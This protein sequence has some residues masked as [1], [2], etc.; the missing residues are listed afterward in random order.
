MTIVLPVACFAPLH[1][2]AMVGGL[3]GLFSARSLYPGW[4]PLHDQSLDGISIFNVSRCVAQYTMT[5]PV[6]TCMVYA[7]PHLPAVGLIPQAWWS[8]LTLDGVSLAPTFCSGLVAYWSLINQSLPQ[9]QPRPLLACKCRHRLHHFPHPPMGIHH[10][11]SP[12]GSLWG[13]GGPW[14]L[15]PSWQAWCCGLG[16]SALP[17]HA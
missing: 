11:R 8:A 12:S 9:P 16:G 5:M 7:E 6:D 10:G 3:A 17:V 15:Q 1:A 2:L 13:W 4:E 14:P